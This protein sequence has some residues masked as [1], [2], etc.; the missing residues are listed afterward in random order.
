MKRVGDGWI[1][2]SGEPI[3]PEVMAEI[4]T[5]ENIASAKALLK[6]LHDMQDTFTEDNGQT[7]KSTL[8]DECPFCGGEAFI[9]TWHLSDAGWETRA[10]CGDCHMAT[11]R[12][13]ANTRTVLTT[14]E[15]ISRLRAIEKTINKWNRRYHARED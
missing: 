8:T 2:E 6:R 9:Q 12:E 4:M 10:V 7:V 13:F 14:G 5:P 3:P 15:E 11:S 1:F